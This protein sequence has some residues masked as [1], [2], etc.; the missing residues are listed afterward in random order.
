M[1]EALAGACANQAV[2]SEKV[3][4]RML[5][6]MKELP[7]DERLKMLGLLSLEKKIF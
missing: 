1:G 5:S 4:R 6:G 7:Y 3:Q 2:R